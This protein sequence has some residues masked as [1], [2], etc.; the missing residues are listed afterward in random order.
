MI[1]PLTILI[2]FTIILAACQPSINQP[3]IPTAQTTETSV[4]SS[5]PAPQNTLITEIAGTSTPIT[6]PAG[7]Q[8]PVLMTATPTPQ[9]SPKTPHQPLI[10]I[11]IDNLLSPE[12]LSLFKNAGGYWTRFDGFFWDLIEPLE[13]VEPSYHWDKV[14]EAALKSA[15]QA[16]AQVVA[17]VHFAPNW[18]QKYPG[19]A[20]GPIAPAA[21]DNFARFMNAL[22]QRYSQPPYNVKY[23]EIGNEPDI[24]HNFVD[25][26]SPFGCWG[27]QNDPYYGGGYYADMLKASYEQVK[28][29]DLQ[30]KLLIGG[31]LL[32]CDPTN[33]PETSLNSGQYKNCTSSRFLEGILRN[34]GGNFFDG[35]SFHAY[36]Y[37]GN[38]AGKYSNPNWHSVW[39]T[40]GPVFI[41]KASFIHDELATYGLSDKLLVN[42]ELALLCGRDGTEAPC[43]AQDFDL[44]KA[45]YLAQANAAALAN[46]V[47]ANIWYSLNGWRGSGLVDGSSKTN[48]AYEADQFSATELKD[49]AFVGEVSDFPG[50]NG[51]EFNQE[52]KRVWL[53]WSLDGDKHDIKLPTPPTHIWDTFG[54]ALPAEADLTITL[55]P[56]YLEWGS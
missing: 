16:G 42:T 27:D 49:A 29:A 1:K 5:S 56:I 15:T 28:S 45:Y 22:V 14:N 35:V 48:S 47:D 30:A 12:Q 18:A 31:L 23:W 7:T 19:V 6:V 8:M 24:D 20:C 51:Y 9:A 13:T 46:G 50:I 26:H 40:T 3:V 17:I 43:R 2:L 34:G 53:L 52:G 10:G 38:Q 11:H 55:A 37:Y 33:P 32:D 39:N 41:A 36:D 54:K 44:T 4:P 21:L 25:P